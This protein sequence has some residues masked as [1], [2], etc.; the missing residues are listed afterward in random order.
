[1]KKTYTEEMGVREIGGEMGEDLVHMLGSL[2]PGRPEVKDNRCTLLEHVSKLLLGLQ[3]FHRPTH[4]PLLLL[5]E[6]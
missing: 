6:D 3:I 1:M 5:A 4:L 2:T